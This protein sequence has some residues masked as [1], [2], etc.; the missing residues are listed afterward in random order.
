MRYLKTV[1]EELDIR[2]TMPVQPVLLPSSSG[3]PP[4]PTVNTPLR[5][6]SSSSSGLN[7]FGNAGFFHGG[8]SGKAPAS[9]PSFSKGTP[10]FAAG[11]GEKTEG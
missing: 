5:S 10:S 1:L 3:R 11:T 8:Q 6:G 9:G 4:I 2:Y 7:D